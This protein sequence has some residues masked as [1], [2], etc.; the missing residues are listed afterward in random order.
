MK[1]ELENHAKREKTEFHE[2]CVLTTPQLS[3]KFLE[4]VLG[5][6]IFFVPRQPQQLDGLEEASAIAPLFILHPCQPM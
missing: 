3:W 4:H 1:G 2:I 5:L 6:A